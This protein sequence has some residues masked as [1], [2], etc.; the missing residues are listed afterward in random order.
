MPR[1]YWKMKEQYYTLIKAVD[2]KDNLGG[3]GGGGGGL[4]M[5]KCFTNDIK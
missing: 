2:K 5:E 4:G 1:S 3:G